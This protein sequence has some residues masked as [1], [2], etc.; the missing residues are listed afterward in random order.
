MEAD[1]SVSLQAERRHELPV[2]LSA[3]E[4][5]PADRLLDRAPVAGWGIALQPQEILTHGRAVRPSHEGRRWRRFIHLSA[6]EAANTA[7]AD[8]AA[9]ATP[10]A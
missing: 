6:V 8:F 4:R 3:G 1:V 2:L 10:A 7:G 5:V 9:P